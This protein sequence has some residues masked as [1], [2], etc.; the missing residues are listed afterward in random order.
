MYGYNQKLNHMKT[1]KIFALFLILINLSCSDSDDSQEEQ[2]AQGSISIAFTDGGG[3]VMENIKATVSNDYT[4]SNTLSINV[5]A[6][7][8]GSSGGRLTLNIVDNDDSLK[9]L[10][11]DN[12]IPIGDT[13]KS[14]YATVKYIDNSREFNG[15]IGAFEVDNY[16]SNGKTAVLS[17]T[18]SS[19]NDNFVNILS[20]I[21]SLILNCPSC[22]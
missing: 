11:K 17:G 12:K 19:T 14:F 13:S 2:L 8:E 7:A 3:F 21:N 20:S 4:T 9:A 22:N 16:V 15:L 10:V 18:F 5:T 6:S 1:I